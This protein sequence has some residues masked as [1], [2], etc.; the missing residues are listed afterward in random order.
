MSG[1]R[2]SDDHH[3]H[4]AETVGFAIVTISSSREQADDEAGEAIDEVLQGTP[5][6]L[7]LRELVADDFDKVQ[8]TVGR[9]TNRDD[10]DSVVT[11]GGTGVTPD[12]ITVEAVEPLFDKTL[13]GFGELFR[14]LSRDEVGTR[15]IGSRATAGVIDDVPVF[16]LPGSRNAAHLGTAELIVPEAPHLVGLAGR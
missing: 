4:D 3:V 1:D 8:A 15:V 5:H 9:L 14:A 16:C 7:V 12:D 2:R 13:P 10:I 6:E 11:T